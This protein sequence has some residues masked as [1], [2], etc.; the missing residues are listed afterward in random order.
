M[1]LFRR[2]EFGT[3]REEA[4][5]YPRSVFQRLC[6]LPRVP[7]REARLRDVAFDLFEIRGSHT[8]QIV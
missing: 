6:L 1:T 4:L 7:R 2:A 3:K 8:A 5:E